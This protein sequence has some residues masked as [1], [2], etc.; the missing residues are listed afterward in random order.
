[1]NSPIR[2]TRYLGAVTTFRT[3]KKVGAAHAALVV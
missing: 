2:A 1:V 3:F